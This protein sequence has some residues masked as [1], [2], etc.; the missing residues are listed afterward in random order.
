MSRM[1]KVIKGPRSGQHACASG[2][3]T[4]QCNVV[5][6]CERLRSS[7]DPDGENLAPTRNGVDLEYRVTPMCGST[8]PRDGVRWKSQ[9]AAPNR[10]MRTKRPQRA[11]QLDRR[12]RG[13]SIVVA[14]G[15]LGP[16]WSRA[17]QRLLGVRALQLYCSVLSEGLG[18]VLR[19][20]G[21][22][23]HKQIGSLWG[24]QGSAPKMSIGREDAD[25]TAIPVWVEQAA[26]GAETK[27]FL[28]RASGDIVKLPVA[29]LN[30]SLSKLA[31]SIGEAFSG[32]R[33]VGEFHLSEVTLG[34]EINAEGGVNLIGTAKAGAK[35]AITLK[36][37][38]PTATEK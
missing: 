36:F 6:P 22:L 9:G 25:V 5:M 35:A 38:A 26:D 13:M 29:T 30:A 15:W 33:Q 2:M 31:S 20:D 12:L 32:L 23:V 17:T 1:G 4:G 14:D 19:W 8:G 10:G 37:V 21:D 11:T 27:S 28:G 16:R 24:W 7:E 34:V 3:G 18:G